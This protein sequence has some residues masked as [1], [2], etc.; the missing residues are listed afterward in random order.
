MKQLHTI[1]HQLTATFLVVLLLPLTAAGIEFDQG[2]L[3]LSPAGAETGYPGCREILVGNGIKLAAMDLLLPL[4]HSPAESFRW[5]AAS[6]PLASLSRKLATPI[7][8][9]SEPTYADLVGLLPQPGYREVEVIGVTQRDGQ[10][11]LRVLVFPVTVDR[12]GTLWWH[13][14]ITLALDGKPVPSEVLLPTPDYRTSRVQNPT[15]TSADA[16]DTYVI[17]TSESLAPALERLASYRRRT[18]FAVRI[19]T[20]EAI[21]AGY[22]G[23]DPAAQVRAFLREFH[24]GGGTHALL[25][26][27]ET[28]VPCR[29]VYQYNITGTPDPSLLQPS[30]LYFADLTGEWD[31]DGDGVYGERSHD[32]PDLTAEL[33]VGRLPLHDSLQ[34]ERYT[35]NLITYET[36]P[37]Y[38]DRDWLTRTLFYSSDQLRDY[39]GVGQHALLAP[40]FSP[41]YTIDTSQTIEQASGVAAAPSNVTGAELRTV[42]HDSYGVVNILAHGRSDGFVVRS[43]AYNEWP[44]S[45]LLISEETGVHGSLDSLLHPG[46]PSLYISLACDNAG[47]DLGPVGAERRSVVQ[48]L[49]S[50]DGGAVGF[51]GNTRWGWVGSSYLL[52]QKVLESIFAN[53]E[54][55]IAGSLQAARDAYPYYRD[56]VYGLNYFGDP[57]TRLHTATPMPLETSLEGESVMKRL[58]VTSHGTPVAG[59]RLVLVDDRESL[60]LDAHTDANGEIALGWLPDNAVYSAAVAKTGHLTTLFELAPAIVTDIDDDLTT[61]PATYALAQ[62]YPNPFNPST[63][64]EYALPE[65]STVRLTIVNMLGREVRT[66]VH[67]SQAAGTYSVAWDALDA[68]GNRCATGVY[69]YR[70][71]AGDYRAV[72]KML[73]VR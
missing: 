60:V 55:P 58:L 6:E 4:G 46:K 32:S 59:V 24:A 5:S 20:V 23:E 17:V 50:R 49:L 9:S 11:Y 64:I 1:R 34:F 13:R 16:G 63:V 36:N 42:L 54:Q 26:G 29:L 69:F 71:Q 56:L 67:E 12:E 35:D 38:G 51:V 7:P 19:M 37:G 8:T 41:A 33:L 25:A 18:G 21:T 39:N 61:I 70:L 31:L 22:S 43:A 28:V 57:A 27:D 30:D 66:L 15:N 73:L 72:R 65:A 44:K 47:Y 3:Q 62:N 68:A 10:G 14:E 40:A 53:P 52:H 2:R 45:Y 48:T